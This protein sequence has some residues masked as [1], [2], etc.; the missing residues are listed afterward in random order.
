MTA[1]LAR[2]FGLE[3]A[4]GVII[5]G[6]MRDGPA[7]KG[8]LKV[9]DIIQSIDGKPVNDTQRLMA[10]IAAKTPCDLLE[11]GIY[12]NGRTQTLALTAGQRPIKPR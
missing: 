4:G 10:R 8:G 9:G 1:D 2:A 7:A 3:R 12:R 11:L 6:M 5:A